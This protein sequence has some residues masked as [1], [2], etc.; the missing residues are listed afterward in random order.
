MPILNTAVPFYSQVPNAVTVCGCS[1][2]VDSEEFLSKHAYYRIPIIMAISWVWVCAREQLPKGHPDWVLGGP[3]RNYYASL[4]KKD[5]FAFTGS[6]Y[7][8]VT[9]DLKAVTGRLRGLTCG[10]SVACALSAIVGYICQYI[11]VPQTSAG[12]AAKWL[13]LQGLFAVIRVA[14][15]IWNPAFDDFVM[16][17][18]QPHGP[19]HHVSHSEAQLIML[20]FTHVHPTKVRRVYRDLLRNTPR[21][22]DEMDAWEKMRLQKT[23]PR[24]WYGFANTDLR[25]ASTGSLTIKHNNSVRDGLAVE[26]R[27]PTWQKDLDD[28]VGAELLWD[29]PGWVFMLWVDAHTN[30]DLLA[31]CS[32]YKSYSCRVVQT[33]NKDYHFIPYWTTCQVYKCIPDRRDESVEAGRNIPND[34]IP[35]KIHGD[36][37]IDDR[38]IAQ[39]SYIDPEDVVVPRKQELLVGWNRTQQER[40]SKR[41]WL[42]HRRAEIIMRLMLCGEN[43]EQCVIGEEKGAIGKTYTKAVYIIHALLFACLPAATTGF[44]SAESEPTPAVVE[45]NETSLSIHPRQ[46][47]AITIVSFLGVGLAYGRVHQAMESRVAHSPGFNKA[48]GS[49]CYN[50]GSWT[51]QQPVLD[52]VDSVCLTLTPRALTWITRNNRDLANPKAQIRKFANGTVLRN[53]DGMEQ[54]LAFTIIDVNGAKAK[55]WL[56]QDSCVMALKTLLYDC[57]GKHADTKGGW[58]FYGNDGVTGYGLDA[59]II[60]SILGIA[61]AGFRLSLVL[62][63][64]GVEMATA[65]IEIQNIARAISNYAFTLKQLALTLE[66]AKSIAT[67]SAMETAEQIADQS[68]MVFDDIKE[69]TE[70]DQRKDEQGNLRSIAVNQRVKW[71]FKQQ[72]LQYLLGQLESLKL[73]LSLMTQVLQFGKLLMSIREDPSRPAPG[74]QAM[75]QERAEIQNMVVVR[76]WS[77]VQLRRLYELAVREEEDQRDQRRIEPP[78]PPRVDGIEHTRPDSRLQIQGPRTEEDL[79]KAVV[80]YNETPV[81]DLDESLSRAMCRPNRLLHA[82][83]NDIVDLLLDEWTRVRATPTKKKHS[84]HKYRTRYDTESE[85]SEI[86]LEGSRNIGG[87]YIGAPPRRPKNVHFQRARV[88]SG[89]EESDHHRPRHRPPRHAVLDSDSVSTSTT[90]SDSESPLPQPAR[91]YSDGSKSK[92]LMQDMADRNR[93]PYT[94]GG[95]SPQTSRPNSRSGPQGPPSSRP[96]IPTQNGSWAGQGPQAQNPANLRPPGLHTIPPGPKRMAP[97]GPV[98]GIPPVQQVSVSPG[99]S[100][101][102]RGMYYPPPPNQIPPP[103][104]YQPPPRQP[105]HKSSKKRNGVDGKASGDKHTF[106]ENAKR[107]VKRG[108]IGAGAVAGLM[109]ILEG[110]GGVI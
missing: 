25:A 72:R 61:G 108:L 109:D 19:G 50:S 28:L 62:N 9:F 76:H 21:T 80:K 11:E 70:L 107:D 100:P 33:A 67:Q 94:S 75:L 54:E 51:L 29:M 79:S 90:D 26:A 52:L 53:E 97:G 104:H 13:A 34:Q 99:T 60:A 106:R 22:K 2:N 77:F 6:E 35:L 69:M 31:K 73:S 41:D 47:I 14:I 23:R 88:E 84:N 24:N 91:R 46:V 59:T 58:Y 44:P 102:A 49:I 39:F 55:P 98:H 93:H 5:Y 56:D 68:Q 10:L 17:R 30:Q 27:G 45:Y 18:A 43:C 89:S 85:G 95:G 103:G 81:H 71:C 87:R 15:W 42:T 38:F 1:M 64:V 40:F 74:E 78:L 36:L 65:D 4:A 48:P 8:Y 3:T 82:P 20:W 12:Q 16:E 92:P 96:I 101:N 66:S 86:D 32:E 63:A 37:A 83:G 105:P 57:W 110:L 7:A